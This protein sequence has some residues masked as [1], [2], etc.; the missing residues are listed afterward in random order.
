MFSKQMSLGYIR[1]RFTRMLQNYKKI[2]NSTNT[3]VNL[4]V[5]VCIYHQYQDVVISNYCAAPIFVD[6][7]ISIY[8]CLFLHHC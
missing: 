8:N 3:C 6:A 5:L 1:F 4:Y 2:I 7:R